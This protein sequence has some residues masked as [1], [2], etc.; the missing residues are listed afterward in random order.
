MQVSIGLYQKNIHASSIYIEG[1]QIVSYFV[2][3]MLFARAGKRMLLNF[4]AKCGYKSH[5]RI[6]WENALGDD[7]FFMHGACNSVSYNPLALYICIYMYRNISRGLSR[8]HAAEQHFAL[9]H[10]ARNDVFSRHIT[11]QRKTLKRATKWHEK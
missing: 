7:I 5:R 2:E 1:N 9:K 4:K 6:A 11:P 3:L 8:P 10:A